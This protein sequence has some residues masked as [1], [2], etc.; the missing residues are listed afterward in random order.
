MI[1]I[2]KEKI[3]L[4]EEL[5]IQAFDSEGVPNK[6]TVEINKITSFGIDKDNSRFI[7]LENNLNKIFVTASAIEKLRTLIPEKEI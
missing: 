4:F 7:K 1:K 2:L 5:R 6:T 3:I